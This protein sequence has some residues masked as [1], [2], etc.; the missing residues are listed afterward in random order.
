MTYFTQHN[1]LQWRVCPLTCHPCCRKWHHFILFLW[2]SSISL[3]VCL[4]IYTTSSLYKLVFVFFRYILRSRIA[5]SYGS[6]IFSF[7]RHLPTVFHMGCINLH[8]Y[9][10]CTR[11]SFCPHPHRYLLFVFCLMTT[12]LTGMRWYLV[13]VLICISLTTNDVEHLFMCLLAISM[14]SLKRCLFGSWTEEPGEL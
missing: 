5:G 2:L 8:S 4:S 1:A 13:V 7:M 6:S 3:S 9:Q 10:Q 12:I 11:V 14:S